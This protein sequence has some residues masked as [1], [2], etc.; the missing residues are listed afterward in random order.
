MK[1][2]FDLRNRIQAGQQTVVYSETAIPV[3]EPVTFFGVLGSHVGN[4]PI[5]DGVVVA[6]LKD[7][8]TAPITPTKTGKPKANA[9]RNLYRI[10]ITNIKE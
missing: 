4:K 5:A 10:Q 9:W 8:P 1:L 2:F 6:A 3:G 7:D